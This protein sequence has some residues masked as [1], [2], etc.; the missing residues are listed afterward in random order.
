VKFLKI[1]I[2]G[3]QR[4]GIRYPCKKMNSNGV[5]V[6]VPPVDGSL[7]ALFECVGLG[8]GFINESMLVDLFAAHGVKITTSQLNGKKLI[9]GGK[10][11]TPYQ[12]TENEM[13]VARLI[14]YEIIG[15]LSSVAN[16]LKNS[17]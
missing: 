6:T 9:Q 3:A 8:K 13:K 10:E 5:L 17:K 7:I 11:Y 12:F 14:I 2:M 4:K 1:L 15:Q 16:V